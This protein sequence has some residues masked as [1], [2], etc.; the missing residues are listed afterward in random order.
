MTDDA[1][2]L[3]KKALLWGL[4]ILGWVAAGLLFY[5]FRKREEAVKMQ[6]ALAAKN[7]ELDHERELSERAR[8]QQSW[9]E[10]AHRMGE[11]EAKAKAIHDDAQK[12]L[13]KL[14]G[15]SSEAVDAA[16]K[17]QGLE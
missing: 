11:L 3:W 12:Q 2:Y 1:S 8:I 17:E 6:A 14:N 16:A 5:V 10:N 13:D 9:R 4:G 7:V 15:A